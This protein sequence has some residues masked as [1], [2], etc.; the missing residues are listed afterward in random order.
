MI[1]NRLELKNFKSH[2]NTTLDFNPGISLIVGENGAGKSTIFE[3]ITFAL[4]KEYSTKTITDLVRSNKNIN[5]KMEMMVKLTF[6]S[7]GHTYRVERGVTL[8][9]SSSKSTS[10]L[11]EITISRLTMK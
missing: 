11:Y 6:Y 7:N 1:F 2:A 4:F 10:D 9:K 8:N 3:A 5:E